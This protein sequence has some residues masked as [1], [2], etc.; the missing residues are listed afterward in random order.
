MCPLT[1][2][3]TQ[4]DSTILLMGCLLAASVDRC[5]LTPSLQQ[6][7]GAASGLARSLGSQ[8]LSQGLSHCGDLS[9]DDGCLGESGDRKWIS[10]SGT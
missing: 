7:L 3:S 8:E 10:C 6:D 5:A 4:R 1:V 2:R 9:V